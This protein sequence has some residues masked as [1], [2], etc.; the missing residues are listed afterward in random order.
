M[1]HMQ[2]LD[3]LWLM[4]L[5]S[6]KYG[7]SL[8]KISNLILVHTKK[9]YLFFFIQKVKNGKIVLHGLIIPNLDL[10]I[11]PLEG[12]VCLNY[13]KFFTYQSPI[14][15]DS[16]VMQ[17]FH[18]HLYSFFFRWELPFPFHEHSMIPW[19]RK[20][21]TTQAHKSNWFLK[22]IPSPITNHNYKINNTTPWLCY[23]LQL[24]APID[25]SNPDTLTIIQS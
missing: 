13:P 3:N 10:Y 23:H 19:R 17:L 18:T 25:A 14:Y 11:D 15:I 22:H 16:H 6:I 5:R 2:K 20:E 12:L 4:I 7:F 24:T 21:E 8:F 9:N 1:R